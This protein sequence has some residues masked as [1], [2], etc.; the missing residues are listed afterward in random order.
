M[1]SIQA[2]WTAV[3]EKLSIV[4]MVLNNHGYGAM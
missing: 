3:Q 1:Y 4:M 2:L